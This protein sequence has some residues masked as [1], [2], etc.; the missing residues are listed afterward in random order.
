MPVE[1][2]S[3][4]ITCPQCGLSNIPER[5]T[6]KHCQATLISTPQERQRFIRAAAHARGSWLSLIPVLGIL[7]MGMVAMLSYFLNPV[8]PTVPVPGSPISFRS[9]R[10]MLL[11]MVTVPPYYGIGVDSEG[12]ARRFPYP[13]E[14]NAVTV[15]RLTPDEQHA[16]EIFRAQ[17]CQETPSFRPLQA[18]EAFYELGVRCAGYEVKQTKVPLELVPPLFEKLMQQ[19]PG[20]SPPQLKP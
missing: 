14:T 5:R 20:V 13:I 1:R 10:I 2:A 17:W 12:Y 9:T 7:T 15:L 6:C 11:R 16:V 4:S 3:L 19:L 18:H 8:P